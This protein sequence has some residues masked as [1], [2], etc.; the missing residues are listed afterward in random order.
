MKLK[1]SLITACVGATIHYGSFTYVNTYTSA[2]RSLSRTSKALVEDVG[3]YFGLKPEREKLSVYEL[4][5]R[6]ALRNNL[7]PA[8]VKAQAKVESNW[9]INAESRVG[10]VGVMQVMPFNFKRCGLESKG[11]LLDP[12]TNIICGTKIIAEELKASKGDVEIALQR[13]NG[14][15]KCVRRCKESVNYSRIVLNLMAKDIG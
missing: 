12:E 13:Y 7:N 5:E 2:E 10:A 8:L 11:Q 1:L 4:A 6:E 9:N 14:G 15:P 3:D